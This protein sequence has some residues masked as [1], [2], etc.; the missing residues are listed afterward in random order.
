MDDNLDNAKTVPQTSN[1]KEITINDI[2]Y[3]SED[4]DEWTEIDDGIPPPLPKLV[5]QVGGMFPAHKY[6]TWKSA[7]STKSVQHNKDLSEKVDI[8][9]S[10]LTELMNKAV[11]E[12]A[13]T[14]AVELEK[15][16]ITEMVANLKDTL[17]YNGGEGFTSAFGPHLDSLVG[18][19][20]GSQGSSYTGLSDS[21]VNNM[22]SSYKSPFLSSNTNAFKNTGMY[23][24]DPSATE[25]FKAH[26]NSISKKSCKEKKMNK[27]K[28]ESLEEEPL[29]EELSEDHIQ[30]PPM[31]KAIKKMSTRSIKPIQQITTDGIT[32]DV[33][34]NAPPEHKKKLIGTACQM[35]GLYFHVDILKINNNMGGIISCWHCLFWTN[36]TLESRL[37]LEEEHNLSLDKYILTC[38]DDHE[39]SKCTRDSCELC[40]IIDEELRLYN[41]DQQKEKENALQV[42]I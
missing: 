36:S 35:C 2:D 24:I 26:C 27:F 9:Q 42:I 5:R 19:A 4:Y 17:K 40:K 20:S 1:Q 8:I 14:G 12:G 31:K 34:T 38:I 18:V 30:Y 33:Y 16:K 39:C 13:S 25:S 32:S 22:F 15:Y 41:L 23:T 7:I 21:N 28:E 29:E 11:E 6:A 3:T 10:T 37:N